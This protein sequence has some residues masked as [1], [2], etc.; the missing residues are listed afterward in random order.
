LPPEERL[1]IEQLTREKNE[2]DEA[3][4][5]PPALRELLSRL[6]ELLPPADRDGRQELELLL[7][8]ADRFGA[9]LD[10]FLEHTA[11]GSGADALRARGS[12]A[13]SSA[14]SGRELVSLLTL[15]AAKGLEFTC[16]YIVGCEDGLLPYTLFSQRGS[17]PEEERRLFYVG[18]TRARRYLY[19]SHARR[20]RLF[21]RELTL[22]R[23][24]F[25]DRIERELLEADSPAP[26]RSRRESDG[27]MELF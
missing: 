9:D 15:H 24:P 3:G 22:R 8:H 23:S 1:R 26:W 17:D 12:A 13:E 11:L 7:E 2:R 16:V 18:M 10:A 19:L 4:M 14:P 20:R 21:G 6:A 27:Q 25:V 5:K